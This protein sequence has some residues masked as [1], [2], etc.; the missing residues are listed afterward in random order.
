[1]SAEG[2]LVMK[3]IPIEPISVKRLT[4]SLMIFAALAAGVTAFANDS[5]STHARAMR[6]ERKE[7]AQQLHEDVSELHATIEVA[8]ASW[9]ASA[10]EFK[11]E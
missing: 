5:V 2:E 8:S 1:M 7:V 3:R 11:C 6:P 9:H 4:S 10:S